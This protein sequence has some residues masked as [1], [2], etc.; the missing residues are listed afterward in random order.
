V[1]NFNKYLGS[2]RQDV[3]IDRIAHLM[4]QK[5]VDPNWY[6][7]RYL[8]AMDSEDGLICEGWLGAFFKRLGNAWSGFWK[9]PTP[10]DSPTSRFEAAKQ[11]IQNLI[12]MVQQNQ[13]AESNVM[14][15]VLRGLEQSLS[16]LGKVEPMLK[17]AEPRIKQFQAAQSGQE[18][19]SIMFHG[20]EANKL[21]DELHQK[22]EDIMHRRNMLVKQ[23]DSEAKITN[24]VK[25]DN[26]FLQFRQDLEDEYQKIAPK[27]AEQE[28]YKERIR[29]FLTRIETDATFREIENLL[30]YARKRT[31]EGLMVSRP[32]GYE[33]VV[34][35]FRNAAAKSNDLGQQK[36]E[37]MHWYQNL[38]SN[39]P[40]KQFVANDIRENPEL[41]NELELFWKYA[42]EWINKL[43]HFLA[44]R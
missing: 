39:N 35:A 41:G 36:S 28:E 17:K 42:Q 1:N 38:P 37:M 22:F 26:E 15:V 21:P 33:Q 4:V 40:V 10:D 9:D 5:N 43:P 29:T 13:G 14:S 27:N 8:E 34:T 32:K 11:A 12:Q 16:I 24:L 23:P 6:I 30:D 3:D 20:D 2:K 19:G 18:A 25:N 7:R 44:S 31:N